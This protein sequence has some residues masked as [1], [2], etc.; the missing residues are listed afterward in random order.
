MRNKE[1]KKKL[2]NAQRGAVT[3]FLIMILV[4]C[5]VVASIFVDASR[6][7][8][9]KAEAE[10]AAD[11]ALNTVLAH[12]DEDL[13]EFYGLIG[14]VQ[15]VDQFM[16]KAGEYFEGMMVANGIEELESQFFIDFIGNLLSG[17]PISDFLRVE[18]SDTEVS[19]MDGGNLANPAMLE[20]QIVQFMKY[21]GVITIVEKLKDRFM[22]IDPDVLEK[23]SDYEPVKDSKTAFAEAESELLNDGFYL[24]WVLRHYNDSLESFV[25]TLSSSPFGGRY[26]DHSY[27]T[28]IK[29]YQRLEED[30]ANIWEDLQTITENIVLYYLVSDNIETMR[31]KPEC[32]TTLQESEYE[33]YMKKIAIKNEEDGEY[34]IEW[35][36]Y[37]A[38]CDA[39]DRT[40]ENT[41]EVARRMSSSIKAVEG[42]DNDVV[43]F[44]RVQEAIRTDIWTIYSDV[45]DLQ[46]CALKLNAAKRCKWQEGTEP[47]NWIADIDRRLDKADIYRYGNGNDEYLTQIDRYYARNP[48]ESIP[49]VK[50]K[51]YHN[52][53]MSKYLG[54]QVTINQFAKTIHDRFAIEIDYCNS[55]IGRL[56]VAINGGDYE[57]Q[58]GQKRK[59]PSVLSLCDDAGKYSDTF[60]SWGNQIESFKG[61]HPGEEEPDEFIKGDDNEYQQ[62]LNYSSEEE[63]VDVKEL[64]ETITRE[65]V[66][67]LNERLTNIRNDLT[68]L[69]DALEGFAYGGRQIKNLE[70]FDGYIVAARE[71]S[72]LNLDN[73]SSTIA[74]GKEQAKDL[75]LNLI[76]PASKSELYKAPTANDAVNGNNPYITNDPIYNLFHK[77]FKDK[78]IN[79]LEDKV[80]KNKEKVDRWKDEAEDQKKQAE[81]LGDYFEGMGEDLQDTT[82]LGGMGVFDALITVM[83]IVTKIINGDITDIRDEIYVVEYIM[84][85]FTYGTI[86]NEGWYSRANDEDGKDLH[87]GQYEE[88]KS[89]YKDQWSKLDKTDDGY[90]KDYNSIWSRNYTLTNYLKGPE[91]NRAYLGEVEYIL[92]GNPSVEKNLKTSFG[93]IFKIRLALN[94]ASGFMNFWMPTKNYTAQV[95][96]DLAI[97]ISAATYGIIPKLLVKVILITLLATMESCE[98]LKFLKSGV[99]VTLFKMNASQWHYKVD[100][101]ES[102]EN[103]PSFSTNESEAKIVPPEDPN[104]LC[105]TDYVYLFL[106]MGTQK[107]Y[108]SI[109]KRTGIV[110]EANMNKVFNKDFSLEKSMVFFH[111]TSTLKVKPLMLDIPLVESYDEGI[112][113]FKEKETWHKYKIDIIRGYS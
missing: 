86:A 13:K 32:R 89:L 18:I 57:V 95:I 66:L 21:R 12:Y 11:L 33:T 90:L 17:E 102:E 36:D 88:V 9:S 63:N 30:F 60:S 8:L 16:A 24:Y 14:S 109:L 55:Q 27:S 4:P 77:K 37:I 34:Y 68:T 83:G 92:Y 23:A 82:Y 98:D 110:I 53:F 96:D 49:K 41:M 58:P 39:F 74:G 25:S 107:H 10:S 28:F 73:I 78:D 97:L 22:K 104:G 71:H 69:R 64:H 46:E 20:N 1:R 31:F 45:D 51:T 38:L 3:V 100:I 42:G 5:I 35:N 50:N 65:N 54:Q 19:A 26:A 81:T 111:L 40:Y 29:H 113:T 59:I 103:E 106:F 94:I 72:G 43:Y 79:E 7:F 61:K 2:H 99:K 80:K 67:N 52:E 44:M 6:V 70:S 93:E 75:A 85:M 84:D 101:S 62:H 15:D 48:E 105:Y 112:S 87:A 47:D 56:N 91:N 76:K 108:N